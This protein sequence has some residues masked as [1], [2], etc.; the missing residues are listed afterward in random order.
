LGAA[1]R[2]GAGEHGARFWRHLC[3]ARWQVHRAFSVDVLQ[4]IEDA[5][6]ASEAQHT[7][8]LR[9]AIEPALGISH[10]FRRTT[11]RDRAVIAFNA[12]HVWDTEANNGVLIFVLYAER[13]IEIVADRGYRAHV[14]EAEWRAA[15]DEAVAAFGTGQYA[16][17]AVALIERVGALIAQVFPARRDDRNEL[18]NQPVV[19]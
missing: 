17:G 9:F 7:G 16:A 5:I 15:C 18:P 11:A 3:T 12:L 6:R 10:L 4:A 1:V 19:L 13:A 2:R 14:S 8:E